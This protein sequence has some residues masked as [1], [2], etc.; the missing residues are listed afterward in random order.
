MR[1]RD[2]LFQDFAYKFGAGQGGGLPLKPAARALGYLERLCLHKT[3]I[4]KY[5]GNVYC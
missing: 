3:I 2:V 1:R 5:Q 4:T